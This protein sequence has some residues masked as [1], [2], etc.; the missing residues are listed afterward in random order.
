MALDLSYYDA[1]SFLSHSVTQLAS[2]H[3]LCSL[4]F[5]SCQAQRNV[6]LPQAHFAICNK[7]IS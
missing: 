5:Y 7:S 4:D 3:S 2:C 1:D 6:D